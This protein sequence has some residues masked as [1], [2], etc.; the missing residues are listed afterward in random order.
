MTCA[1]A[2]ISFI[3]SVILTWVVCWFVG[4][5]RNYPLIWLVGTAAT[6]IW[7]WLEAAH[8]VAGRRMTLLR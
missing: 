2:V 3:P 7:V 5:D 1:M 4:L 8:R 6:V